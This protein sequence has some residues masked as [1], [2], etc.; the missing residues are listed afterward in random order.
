MPSFL[1]REKILLLPLLMVLFWHSMINLT[2][3]PSPLSMGYVY[4]GSKGMTMQAFQG[5]F[6][7]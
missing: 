1:S 4:P 2:L 3:L 5:V 7:L 6:S